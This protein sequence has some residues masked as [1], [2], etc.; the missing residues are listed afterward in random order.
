MTNELGEYVVVIAAWSDPQSREIRLQDVVIAGENVIPIFSS[1][2]EFRDQAKGSAFE[3]QGLV[4][5]RET[6]YSLLRGDEILLLNPG[7]SHPVRLRK[8]DLQ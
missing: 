7:C 3:A 8:A 1:E 4:L 5:P 6:L 2:E